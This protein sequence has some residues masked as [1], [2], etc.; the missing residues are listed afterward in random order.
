MVMLLTALTILFDL[1]YFIKGIFV[2]LPV[3]VAV[4]FISNFLYSYLDTS[5]T[6]TSGENGLKQHVKAVLL[7]QLLAYIIAP[8]YFSA[9]FFKTPL[10][11][12]G[13]SLISILSIFFICALYLL[14]VFQSKF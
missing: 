2:F 1:L 13:V 3:L 11:V 7:Y 9:L 6:N 4:K 10:N 8:V 12:I 5:I 14:Y